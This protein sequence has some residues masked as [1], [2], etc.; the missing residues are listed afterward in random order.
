MK[1]QRLLL[2]ILLLISC[3]ISYGDIIPDNSHYVN[4]CVK[5]TNVENYPEI[6]LIGYSIG[7]SSSMSIPAYSIS[8]S[9]CLTKGYKYNSLA[10]YA[11]QKSYLTGKDI[12]AIDWTKDGNA[13]KSNMDIE[14]YGGFL[15]DSNPISAIDQFYRIV[16][17]TDNSVVLYKWKEINKFNNGKPDS[18]KIYAFSGDSSKLS[19]RIMTKVTPIRYNSTIDLYPNPAHKNLHIKLNNSYQGDVS[20]VI[21]NVEGKEVKSTHVSKPVASADY[22]VNVDHLARGTYFVSIVM[23]KAVV[24][25][26]FNIN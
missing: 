24:C 4:K 14:C 2:I 19:Q 21:R 15:D 8:S 17:F 23:G 22:S 3:K 5:I 26:I 20:F 9:D 6:L 10:I 1:T 11:A 13:V 12:T 16:G 18:T 25:K 7:V